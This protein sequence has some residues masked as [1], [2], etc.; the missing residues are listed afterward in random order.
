[1]DGFEI[2]KILGAI[3]GTCLFTLS[4]NIVAGGIFAPHVPAK[5]GYE[6]AVP[7]APA[8]GAQAAV[9]PA[10]PIANRLA[11]AD[12]KKGEAAAKKCVAC[13]S[14][15]KG[16]ANKVG[17]NLYGVVGG[18][19]AHAQG[20]AYSGAMKQAGG[21]WDFESLDKFLANPKAE[22]KNTSMT[23]VGIRRPEERADV[24]AYL[25]SLADSPKPLPKPEGGA[26]ADAGAQKGAPA[27]KS[28]ASAQK[29]VPAAKPEA[30][31]QKDAP[32]AKSDAGAQKGVPAG[33]K[34]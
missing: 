31:A 21:N 15:E 12:P 28:E 1:M 14:F 29:E 22:V 7:D 11:G 26:K 19:R 34:K 8:G 16:G 10:E 5:P 24:I 2:N 3:L 6:I 9:P 4:L 33:Q 13:H 32:A 17:P 18:P 23:F 25:N 30:S 27:A 20:F